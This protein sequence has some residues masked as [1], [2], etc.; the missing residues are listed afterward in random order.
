MKYSRL[1]EKIS[2]HS[3]IMQLMDDLGEAMT[4]NPHVKMLGGGNPAAIPELQKLWR[5]QTQ[6]AMQD[7]SFDRMLGNY[8]PPQGNPR[9]LSVLAEYLREHCGWDVTPSNLA[10]TPGGQTAFFLLFNLLAGEMSDPADTTKRSLRKILL[11]ISP[12]Y[13]GYA[14]QGLHA[15]MFV[16]CRGKIDKLR[17]HEF[18][19]RVDFEAV[20]SAIAIHDIGAICVSRPT[21]PTGNV[22][23]TNEVN[24]LAEIAHSREIP[25]IIDNAYGQPFP[26]VVFTDSQVAWNDD[27]VFTLSL[28]KLGLPGTRTGIVVASEEIATRISQTMGV[29][30]LANTNVGQSLVMPLLEDGSLDRI[31]KETVRPFYADK[32]KFARQQIASEFG[33]RFEYGIH[34]SEGAFFLWLTFPRLSV[35]TMELYEELKRRDVIV[36]PGEY[37]FFGLDDDWDHSRQCI[38]VSFA[39]A[40]Q[41]VAEGIAEIADVVESMQRR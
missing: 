29:L 9:F 1:G 22:L 19:Y 3:G 13:I 21:N 35:P 6:A 26:G 16:S 28:S 17:E 24:R 41:T 33:N 36:V 12:E 11:P 7:G 25:F 38:R 37:F 40:D 14:D 32:S 27:R 30:G 2:S 5:D 39:L 23:T 8:D 34:V 4:L 18:K 31:C 15:D 10:V 20:D